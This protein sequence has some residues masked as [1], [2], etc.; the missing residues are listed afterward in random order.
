[1]K[2]GM[3]TEERIQFRNEVDDMLNEATDMTYEEL[4]TRVVEERH[5]K[6]KI[7]EQLAEI[8]FKKKKKY[9]EPVIVEQ[10][11]LENILSVTTCRNCPCKDACF[12]EDSYISCKDA[13]M[14]YLKGEI[15][16]EWE[17]E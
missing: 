7:K 8:A 12:A 16:R 10:E 14:Q 15:T 3:T 2:D 5:E 6:D 4:C 11:K 13:K 9:W 1:M 17:E